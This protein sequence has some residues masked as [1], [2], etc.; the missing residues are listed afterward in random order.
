M[1]PDIALAYQRLNTLGVSANRLLPFEPC[2][3]SGRTYGTIP[4]SERTTR[5]A[6]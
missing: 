4:P 5:G 2:W 1:N 6:P 3:R